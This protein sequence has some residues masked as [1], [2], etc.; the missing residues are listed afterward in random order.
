ME[1]GGLLRNKER[2]QTRF[3]QLI[4]AEEEDMLA[5]FRD[6][7]EQVRPATAERVLDFEWPV[8]C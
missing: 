2:E 4:D 5:A 7:R 3:R 6:A 1:A 8:W